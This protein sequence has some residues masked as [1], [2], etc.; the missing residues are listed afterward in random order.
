MNHTTGL[1]QESLLEG[2]LPPLQVALL[3]TLLLLTAFFLFRRYKNTNQK[4]PPIVSGWIPFV[5]V[6]LNFASGPLQYA[7][8]VYKQKG[9]IFTLKL[10]GKRLTFL[11]GPEAHVPFFAK[12]DKE[13]SQDE[14]YQFSVPIFGPNVV[15]GADLWHRNQQLKFIAASLSSKA[16]M[17]YV[18]MIVKEAEDYFAQWGQQGTV[19]IRHALSELIILTAS[20][21]L[22]GREIRENLFTQV[23]KLYQDLDEG[24]TPLSFFFPHLP[25][26]AH[27]RRDKARLEMV[28]LFSKIIEQRR[29][30][31]DVKHDVLQVFMDA[32]YPKTGAMLTE[33]EITGMMIA[34]LF[35]GQHTS[36]VTGSWT[37]LLLLEKENK[38]K[39]LQGVMQEQEGIIHELGPEITYEALS[40]MDRLHRCVKEALRMYPPLI[41]LMRQVVRPFDYKG[42]TV[43]EGDILFVSPALSM[44]L[45]EVYK[46]PDEFNPERFALAPEE[47]EERK[48]SYL[49]FG[50]GRH[51]CMGESFAYLQVKTIW[52]VL[53]R[54]FELELEGPLPEPDYRAMVVGPSRPCNLH[55]RRK[56]RPT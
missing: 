10:F 56:S 36:S 28:E 23:A 41:F 46:H 30:Q 14:P 1:L 37:G 16:L 11:V 6:G 29:A 3:P 44:R 49:G 40:K 34:L 21:C 4:L 22:M 38:K 31:P 39:F 18:P 54:S 9:E 12:S 25:I 26:P 47:R 19:D 7:T 2:G 52:A 42:Y 24:L 33:V 32:R 5:G 48:Y 45:P 53:L 17:S 20:R 13:L 8:Q 50:A 55:Y 51:A 43:P 27:K 15:Y 35:A